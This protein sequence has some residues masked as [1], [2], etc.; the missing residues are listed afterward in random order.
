MKEREEMEARVEGAHELAKGTR[1]GAATTATWKGKGKER[2]VDVR[3]G[4]KMNQKEKDDYKAKQNEREEATAAAVAANLALAAQQLAQVGAPLLPQQLAAP[5]LPQQQRRTIVL[6]MSESDYETDSH[7]DEDGS[8]SSE[9]MSGDEVCGFFFWFLFIEVADLVTERTSSKRTSSR[10]E[11]HSTSPTS[12]PCPRTATHR[13]PHR[14]NPKN[15]I[16]PDQH[17][18]QTHLT[19]ANPP[20][21][22][23]TNTQ[24]IMEKAAAEAQ[25]QRDMFA[26]LPVASFQNLERG[27]SRT[28]SAGLLT[29]LLNPPLEIFPANHPYRRG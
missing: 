22:S 7:D 5:L 13:S 15:N 4:D 20:S 23:P 17:T 27:P 3:E 2:E 6:A 19:R 28:R 12:S 18:H 9:E 29:Q 8:W 26:K 24:A 11:A 10:S 14:P 25:R 1:E 16:Q 21:P